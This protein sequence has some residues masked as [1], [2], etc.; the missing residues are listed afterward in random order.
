MVKS[1]GVRY[2]TAWKLCVPDT[3]SWYSGVG[4]IWLK[5]PPPPTTVDSAAAA[6]DSPVTAAMAGHR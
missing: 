6:S 2:C 3:P 1:V 4:S 5:P